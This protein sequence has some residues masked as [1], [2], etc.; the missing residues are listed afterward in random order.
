M[1][2]RVAALMQALQ[3]AQT[4]EARQWIAMQFNLDS[5]SSE[6]RE[7][8][9]VAAIPQW[10][11]KMLL[12]SLLE[13]PLSEA[14]FN[15]LTSLSYIEPFP[16]D[17]FFDVHEST[18]N[19]LLAK[20]FQY[21]LQRYRK[22]NRRAAKYCEQQNQEE[23]RWRVATL[24]HQVLA[25]L[26]GIADEF[27]NQAKEWWNNFQLNKLE[28]LIYLM[29]EEVHAH[30]V[31]QNIVART[32]F[33]QSVLDDFYGRLLSAK[34]YLSQ[35]QHFYQLVG[36]D[37]GKT[38]CIQRLGD[39][40]LKSSDFVA[41][42][43]QYQQALPLFQQIENKLGEANCIRGLGDVY[44]RL[45][46]YEAAQT[47]YQQA[48]LLFQ[49][50][51]NKLG[52]ANCIQGL[53]DVY[54]KLSDYEAARTQYQQALL[55]FQQIGDKLG[56]ANC[57]K[58]L[59]QV[60]A[61]Q[62]QIDEAIQTLQQAAALYRT[63]GLK[64]NEAGCFDRIAN[65]YHNQKRYEDSLTAYQHAIDIAPDGGYWYHNRART[66]IAMEKYDLALQDIERAEKTGTYLEYLQAFRGE[67]A[68]AQHQPQT[69]V[70]LLQHAT[71]QR[72]KDGSFQRSLALALLAN[73]NAEAF[74]TMETGLKLTYAKKDVENLLEELDKLVRIYGE[75]ADFA[76]MRELVTNYLN[77]NFQS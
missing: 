18:R 55:L 49:Q 52:E 3:T 28:A 27:S 34:R 45:S 62:K 24:Y 47:Q 13:Q 8:V 63:I 14:D 48:L 4:D 68:L 43:T 23:L 17:G 51:E 74:A 39:V 72:P 40:H 59:G 73:G 36:D 54:L 66:Y 25:D 1:S 46:D 53:G 64:V 70:E 44:L 31:N 77:Q 11:D 9:W 76:Q 65:I 32:N 71:Q 57:I 16:L 42:R 33:L 7:A 21:D 67:I 37:A 29:W 75:R 15:T 58:N 56:E 22:L 6:V 35:A 10:F 19:L 12:D 38:N 60:L 20:I 2:D 61:E 50:I 30:R 69:A 41:A 5:L 26:D